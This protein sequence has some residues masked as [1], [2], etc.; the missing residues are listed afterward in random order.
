MYDVFK[1]RAAELSGTFCSLDFWL[2]HK[3]VPLCH[4]LCH[5]LTRRDIDTLIEEG[6]VEERFEQ[7]VS[8]FY[9]KEAV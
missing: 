2:C 1:T 6:L 4:A 8:K 5:F 3:F 9:A 7:G